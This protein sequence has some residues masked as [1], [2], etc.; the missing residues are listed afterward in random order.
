MC[1]TLAEVQSEA[2]KFVINIVGKQW[3]VSE[4]QNYWHPACA[5]P[6]SLEPF[7]DQ[8]RS[9]IFAGLGTQNK[10]EACFQGKQVE[11]KTKTK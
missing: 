2:W 4:W 3:S 10:P 5:Q 1:D 6:V 11:F 9:E 8:I 7:W